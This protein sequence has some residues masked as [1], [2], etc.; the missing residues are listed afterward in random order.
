MANQTIDDPKT[1]SAVLRQLETTDPAHADTFNPL[2]KRLI[3]NDEFIKALAD[4]VAQN[5]ASH[6]ADKDNPH[7]TT[8]SE[9]GAPP[10]SR[11]IATSGALTGGGDLKQ[12]R[13]ITHQNTPGFKHVPAGGAVGQALVWAG[14]GEAQWGTGVDANNGRYQSDFGFGTPDLKNCIQNGEAVSLGALSSITLPDLASSLNPSSAY[15]YGLNVKPTVDCSAITVQLGANNTGLKSLYV[16][17]DSTGAVLSTTDISSVSNGGSVTVSVSLQANVVYRIVVDG[18]GAGYT[19]GYLTNTTMP[20]ASDIVVVAGYS[21]NG[22]NNTTIYAIKSITIIKSVTSGTVTKTVTP[23]DI[24]KWGNLKWTQTK[25]TNT[26]VVCDVLDPVSLVNCIPIMTGPT[27]PSGVASASSNSSVA[28]YVFDGN[29]TTGVANGFTF[30]SGVL[31]G[32]IQY[33]FQTAKRITTYT[34]ASNSAGSTSAPKNWTLKGS[35][36]GTNFTVID[37]VTNSTGWAD[38]EKRTFVV[39]TPG[40]YTYYRVDITA[41]NGD[42]TYT[43]V[44]EIEMY[45]D[46][47]VLKSN[48]TSIA[49]LSDLSITTYP[50]LTLRWT[51]TR[52][53]T[54]DTSPTVSNPSITWEGDLN[55]IQPNVPMTARVQQ[56]TAIQNT[57]YTILDVQNGKGMLNRVSVYLSSSIAGRYAQLKITVDGKAPLYISTPTG[58]GS[59]TYSDSQTRMEYIGPIYFKSSL[60]VEVT[61]TSTGTPTIEATA[62]Y[63]LVA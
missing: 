18:N 19:C 46:M 26:N 33:Q 54:S 58:N 3:N 61:C 40:N 22:T 24:K 5:L 13:T 6:I 20:S 42:A 45:Q 16:I 62:D 52:N 47:T 28:F 17:N 15:K 34:I 63:A 38:Y 53:S 48:I 31:T 8:A 41:N 21:G 36:D 59:I 43:R 30:P 55:L 2:F 27:T 50:S 32:W 7:G 49:D 56:T 51:L 9:V 10:T 1:Y 57:Y 39:D 35:N 37:T 12:D 44:G 11:Q 60:K 14:D 4:Q 23:S 25:P 29:W